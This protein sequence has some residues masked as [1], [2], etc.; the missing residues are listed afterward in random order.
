MPSPLPARPATIPSTPASQRSRREQAHDRIFSPHVLDT[1][2]RSAPRSRRTGAPRGTLAEQNLPENR[3]N[4][5][6]DTIME[7]QGKDEDGWVDNS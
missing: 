7:S 4:A 6:I 3:I 2:S 5:L 1:P